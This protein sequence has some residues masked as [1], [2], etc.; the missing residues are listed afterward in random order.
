MAQATPIPVLLIDDDPVTAAVVRTYLGHQAENYQLSVVEHY[1][2]GITEATA[3]KHDALIVDDCLDHHTGTQLLA[4][5][6]QRACQLPIIILTNRRDPTFDRLATE[7]GASEVLTRSELSAG[8]LGRTLR[9]VLRQRR[10]QLELE[11]W[12]HGIRHLPAGQLAPCMVVAVDGTI[13][14]CNS[15]LCAFAGLPYGAVVGHQVSD[16]LGS[17]LDD[18]TP[19]GQWNAELFTGDDEGNRVHCA[20]VAL[21]DGAQIVTIEPTAES[22]HIFRR[23]TADP[24]E[25]NLLRTLIEHLPD[26]IYIKDRRCRFVLNNPEHL[27]VL[28]VSKQEQAL[29]KTDHDFF[30][31]ELADLYRNDDRLVIEGGRVVLDRVEQ[32][33]TASGAE[34]WVSASK[35]PLRDDQGAIIGLVGMSRD[36]TGRMDDAAAMAGQQRRIAAL[37]AAAPVI[38]FAFDRDGIF[39]LAEGKGLA[40]LELDHTDMAGHTVNALFADVP[41]LVELCHRALDGAPVSVDEL[42]VR[43]RHLTLRMEPIRDELGSVSEVIG[44]GYDVTREHRVRSQ[45]RLRDEEFL[46]AQK[47]E[48]V[49]R[50]AGGVAHDFNNVLTAVLGHGELL[51]ARIGSDT[52]AQRTLSKILAV[53]RKGAAMTR[54]LLA[55][56]RRQP[57][58]RTAID[59]IAVVR[60]TVDVAAPLLGEGIQTA[61]AM[62]NETIHI[63]G[64]EAQLEQVLLNLLVNARD[65]MGGTG[66]ITVSAS[67]ETNPRGNN[68]VLLAV[69]DTGCGMDEQTRARCFDPFYTTKSEGKGTGLGLATVR[70]I[71]HEAGGSINVDSEPGAGST[72]FITLPSL[73]ADEELR[74]DPSHSSSAAHV[75]IAIKGHVAVVEDQPDVRTMMAEVLTDYGCTVASY[76]DGAEAWTQLSNDHIACDMVVTDIHMPL[77]DGIELARRLTEIHPKLPVLFVSGHVDEPDEIPRDRRHRLLT[78]PFSHARLLQD[79][80]ELLA[81]GKQASDG[82]KGSH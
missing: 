2:E 82:Q 43:N 35:V 62:P 11:A 12:R 39:T 9:Y 19:S 51:R 55:F 53:A 21:P 64:D 33:R 16:I 59:F 38:L 22:T 72:F 60:A 5:L 42:V 4:S 58:E 68:E 3:G 74:V 78:K 34:C 65:A 10:D 61:L 24:Q 70:D 52:E 30:P 77:M 50:L 80:G 57:I 71:V 25:A 79:V 28:G 40:E 45:L 66:T 20:R 67:A 7:L 8:A 13:E 17:V 36:I 49:G 31:R 29:G 15:A 1:E 46:Q 54:R 32:V 6:Q 73:D 47:M 48:A 76:A 63:V 75:A 18:M 26:Q 41:E 23:L 37:V 14:E 27:Q 81:L 56:C 69:S 44:V